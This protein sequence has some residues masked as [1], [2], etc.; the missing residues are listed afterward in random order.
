M[1]TSHSTC[2]RSLESDTKLRFGV[3]RE[4][5]RESNCDT[6]L[7][8]IDCLFSNLNLLSLESFRVQGDL[9]QLEVSGIEHDL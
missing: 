4:W 6:I 8:F 1:H 5:R 3:R 9:I 7:I 2:Q